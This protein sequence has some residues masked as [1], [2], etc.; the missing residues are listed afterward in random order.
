MKIDKSLTFNLMA[1]PNISQQRSLSTKVIVFPQISDW[2][3]NQSTL[4]AKFDATQNASRNHLI[5]FIFCLNTVVQHLVSN[6]ALSN[7]DKMLFDKYL[8]DLNGGYEG[9][10]VNE[11]RR[12]QGIYQFNKIKFEYSLGDK[13]DKL[14]DTKALE[15]IAKMKN[16]GILLNGTDSLLSQDNVSFPSEL[17]G[18]NKLINIDV[19]KVVCE[20]LDVDTAHEIYNVLKENKILLDMQE[21]NMRIPCLWIFLYHQDFFPTQWRNTLLGN[22]AYLLILKYIRQ[23]MLS[24]L[25]TFISKHSSSTLLEIQTLLCSYFALAFWMR[26]GNQNMIDFLLQHLLL[27]LH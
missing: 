23:K 6:N 26:Q 4:I 3:D 27:Y 8:Q 19:F 20:L 18:S 2:S 15:T 25:K 21:Q 14:D 24:A 9:F 13:V 7:E 16:I 12:R 22:K 11:I 5:D 17:V 1:T 10:G